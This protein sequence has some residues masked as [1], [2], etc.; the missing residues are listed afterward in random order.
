[1]TDDQRRVTTADG[2]TAERT[3]ARSLPDWFPAWARALADLYFSGTTC[4][5][6]LHGNV[7]DLVYSRAESGDR[8]TS[9]LDFL[10]SDLFGT[11]DV[12]LRY[13]L[14]HGLRPAAGADAQRL[15]G[16]MKVL[17]SQLGSP[18]Q[19]PKNPDDVLRVLDRL[20]ERNLLET[21]GARRK[22]MAIIFQYAEYLVPAADAAGLAGRHGATLVRFLEWAQNPYIKRVN[23]AFCLIAD[24]LADMSGR[25]AQSPHVAT[26]EV[27]LPGDADRE[28]FI[29]Q[30][31]A[32]SELAQT[33][34]FTVEQLT[35]LSRGLSLTSLNLLLAQ[36]R[37]SGV[38]ID[39]Q[40]FRRVKKT[41]IE[42][43]C[44]GLL[45]FI[46]P[47]HTLD[48]VVG[49]HAAVERLREDARFVLQGRLDTAPMGYLICGPVGTGKTFLAECYA[50]S[51]GIPCVKMLNFRSKYVGETE[52]N[53]ERVLSVLRS[54]GPV[55]VVI[56]EAD[57]A[58]G[59]REAEGDSGTSSRVFSMIA[60]QMGD[61]RY[62]GRILWMLLTS[63]PD[64]LP[65]DL[66]R[67]GRAEVHI[68]LFAPDDEQ[69]I[70][71]MFTVMARKNKMPLCA[72][73]IPPVSAE[74]QLSGAD[75]ESVVLSAKRRALTAG[76]TEITS[77]DLSEAVENFIPSAQGLEKEKQ[78]IAA[79]L[80]CTDL[81]FLPDRWRTV[82]AGPQGRTQLQSRMA[83]IR[84]VLED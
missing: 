14:A 55:V 48:L 56:D 84:S 30:T 20:I 41:L 59:T 75:I 70:R 40:Q 25:L 44:Q 77:A 33:T 68:P 34:D 82:V 3:A 54:L 63:R 19:W 81:E 67:Q 39:T 7:H 9:V 8:H 10:A 45:E 52:G 50:G 22:S 43:Q 47:P 62:R 31:A 66:K 38:R 15:H 60:S 42:R 73:S 18:E 83:A 2:L 79:V 72:D 6:V 16:M 37:S 5:F 24:R 51:I 57:A 12:V 23:M 17:T 49:H 4:A 32:A 1:M 29:R 78:E 69:E 28:R 64:L 71:D 61:T 46:E 53:L 36:G 27:P 58:L 26:L 65:I 21:D 13:D 76:R 80:E 74:R 11:W 35:A